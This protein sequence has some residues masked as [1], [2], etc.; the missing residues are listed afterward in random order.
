MPKLRVGIIGFAQMHITTM[1]ESFLALPERFC[2]IGCADTADGLEPIST[3]TGTR[4]GTRDAILKRCAPLRE[5]EDY[6]D[7]LNERPDLVIVTCENSRHIDV[8]LDA[9]SRGIHVIMEKPMAMTLGEAVRMEAA[10]RLNRAVLL[11]NW[12][13]SWMP[14]M[15][16]AQRLA[17]AGA[18]GRVLRFS[19]TNAESLGPFSYGQSLSP[20]EKSREW[21]YQRALGGGGAV[22]Y[23]GYGCLLSRWFLGERALAAMATARNFL[24]DF[25]DVEDHATLVLRYA[26]AQAL[27]EGTW[28]TFSSGHIPSGPIVYGDRGTIVADKKT[29]V[30]QLYTERFQATPSR[31]FE[32]EPLPE[33]RDTLAL[34]FLS[35]LEN[36]DVHPTLS[37]AL[38]VAAMAAMDAA[39]RSIV[40][41]KTELVLS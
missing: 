37:A 26:R 30:V 23:L 12:P 2:L 19:Y 25:A 27:I 7:L 8:V 16:T 38:N 35:A 13:T 31:V 41:G 29:G 17:Q 22:D 4:L 6:R 21:W 28:A 9:L 20:L 10:A 5:F 3:E 33:G 24:T 18:V 34:E 39:L 1:V 14:A 36:G 15:R 40:S 11:V 32:N